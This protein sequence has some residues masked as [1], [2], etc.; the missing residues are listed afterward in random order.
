[1]TGWVYTGVDVHWGERY[2]AAGS[3]ARVEP[4]RG[5][6]GHVLEDV[7]LRSV[8]SRARGAASS[9]QAHLHELGGK[10]DPV[11]GDANAR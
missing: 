10:D 9:L 4:G 1:M 2:H 11:G 5:L 8:F 3:W 7:D 6:V